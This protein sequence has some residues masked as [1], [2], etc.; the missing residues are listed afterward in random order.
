MLGSR[1]SRR[2][3]VQAA[4][5]PREGPVRMGR[6]GR[7]YSDPGHG[8]EEYGR[9]DEG[10]QVDLD[11]KAAAGGRNWDHGPGRPAGAGRDQRRLVRPPTQR[12]VLH[13]AVRPRRRVR[14]ESVGGR[15]T[16]GRS[17]VAGGVGAA[18][19]RR[20][21]LGTEAGQ[22]HDPVEVHRSGPASGM[23]VSATP[24]SGPLQIEVAEPG[25]KDR[26]PRAGEWGE[27]A[28]RRPPA[29]SARQES[30][31]QPTSPP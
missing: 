21:A 3:R 6:S 4:A 19:T 9:V 5:G 12:D 10:V 17:W 29:G 1:G 31:Y 30:P 8:V 20:G 22:V 24:V 25:Q 28:G 11:V 13:P 23:A 15:P 2:R 14:G 18:R 26:P 27:P 16:S 7:R